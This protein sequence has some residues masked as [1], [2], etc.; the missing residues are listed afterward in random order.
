MIT[1]RFTRRSV[2]AGLASLPCLS[3]S[4]S[5]SAD[6]NGP[7]VFAAASMT[8]ALQRAAERY[9]KT[10]APAPR[11]SFASS[12]ILAKQIAQ[13]APADLFVSASSEWMDWLSQKSAIDTQSRIDIAKTDL[14]IVGPAGAKAAETAASA[15]GEKR[16]AMGDPGHVPA[17]IYAKQALESEG[18][19]AEVKE[20]AVL[21][22]NARITL[23]LVRRG[24][25]ARAIVY[26]ADLA[27]APELAKIYT[28]PSAGHDPITYP[29][30]L[31]SAGQDKEGAQAFLKFVTGPEGQTALESAGFRSIQRGHAGG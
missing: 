19:W 24:E 15:L 14:V 3:F 16:F 23:E 7:L 21:G 1:L 28:F 2:L 18:N 10:S 8:D 12:S 20:H 4:S 6:G 25:V 27:A 11:F 31:T 5:A 26:A 9:V 30:A 17:G 22:E 13:G 29:A